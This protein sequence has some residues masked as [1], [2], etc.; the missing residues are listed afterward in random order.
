MNP[1]KALCVVAILAT[2]VL[3]VP[4]HH[5]HTL[6]RKPT[7]WLSTNQLSE[8]PSVE[9]VSIQNLESMSLEEGARAL[10]TIY[11]VSQINNDL[12]PSFTPSANQIPVTIVKSNGQHVSTTLDKLANTANQMPYF[13]KQEI[14]VFIT[15]LPS[16]KSETV[17]KANHKLVE[18]YIERFNYQNSKGHDEASNA[19]N[20]VIIDLGDQL[21]SS[22]R[23]MMLDI[24]ETGTKIAHELIKMIE[25]C[26][27]PHD[28]IHIVAQNIAAHVAGACGKEF[29]RQTGKQFRR[30]TALDPSRVYAK[31]SQCLLSLARGDAEFIDAIHTSAWGM[32]TPARVGDVDIFP[33]GPSKG[34]PGCDNVVE[35]SMRATHYFAESV[36]P[37]Q[38]HNFPAEETN[39]YE[40]FKSHNNCG[41]RVYM[42]LAI[43]KDAEGDYML[44]VNE[45]SPFGKRTPAH[46]QRNCQSTHKSYTTSSS[47]WSQYD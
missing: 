26:R 9:D 35:A 15:G 11:H 2:S 20:L 37:G 43:D 39:S 33:N 4:N 19:G 23:Y 27:V 8:A 21:S 45:K 44:E 36:R 34:V 14:T 46:Q 1:L 5:Q 25:K 31:E 18:A 16:Q 28:T 6:Q 29:E 41:K 32:G 24:R 12:K 40:E 7:Q 30:I 3:A 38:E 13:G 22:K 47:S 42:G 10:Q 17:K